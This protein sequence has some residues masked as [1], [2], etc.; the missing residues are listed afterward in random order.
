MMI[1]S[2][3]AINITAHLDARDQYHLA[4]LFRLQSVAA[5]AYRSLVSRPF[6]KASKHGDVELL[7]R[8]ERDR[9]LFPYP[10]PKFENFAVAVACRFRHVHVL[11]WWKN[12]GG[13]N[14]S[15]VNS[16]MFD[17]LASPS[18]SGAI[19]VLEWWRRSGLPMKCTTTSL[20][21]ASRKGQVSVLQWW[22]ESG[23]DLPAGARCL[24]AASQGRHIAVLQWWKES[25][26]PL[27]YTVRALNIAISWGRFDV[28]Q[29]WRDSGLELKYSES[30][31]W[32]ASRPV[33][34]WLKQNDV[35]LIGYERCLVRASSCGDVETLEFWRN[36]N[37]PLQ[38][39]E[40]PIDAAI[41]SGNVAALQWWKGNLELKYTRSYVDRLGRKSA[42]KRWF[43]DNGLLQS[44]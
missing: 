6:V 26:L 23:V 28:L 44:E 34:L 37:Q 42:A 39:S 38:Y 5:Y 1:P 43:E 11:E 16:G 41:R 22:R 8:L 15:E 25:G 20:D 12:A 4:T 21:E 13:V 3:I 27:T 2:H 24:D 32:D 10:H 18:G 36:L 7:D 31:I 17:P 35:E 9:R 30:V 33:L 29:W 14:W 19:A 40:R